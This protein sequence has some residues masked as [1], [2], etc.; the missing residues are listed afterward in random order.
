MEKSKEF[1]ERWVATLAMVGA[2]V[3]LLLSAGGLGFFRSEVKKAAEKKA[4]EVFRDISNKTEDIEEKLNEHLSS[5]DKFR[6]EMEIFRDQITRELTAFV[7][8]SPYYIHL[9]RW[10]TDHG[11]KEPGDKNRPDPNARL[12]IDMCDKALELCSGF[13]NMR[14]SD[15]RNKI[16]IG[17]I[18]ST[19]GTANHVAGEYYNAYVSLKESLKYVP[20]NASTLYNIACT[21]SRLERKRDTIKYLKR[22][23]KLDPKR[24]NSASTD[25]AFDW[26]RDN[27]EVKKIVPK[28]PEDNQ[29]A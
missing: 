27:H 24:A 9:V 10:T 14:N 4:A 3:T 29:S 23:I 21:T 12:V 6:S 22:A 11:H 15:I 8:F 16:L 19:K 18:Y 5:R 20:D 17:M 28:P 25:S 1:Y 26:I 2:G 13:H 7:K